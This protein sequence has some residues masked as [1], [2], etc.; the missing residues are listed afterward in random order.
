MTNTFRVIE[1]DD[2]NFPCLHTWG[3]G[4]PGGSVVKNLP[5]NA[6]DAGD[7]GLVLGLGRS[8][9]IGNGNPLQ[10]SYLGNSMET[11]AWLGYS[12]WGTKSQTQLK[13]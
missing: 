1:H 7:A 3:L 4:F 9:G 6:E 8:P 11:G 10:Y 12:P 13:G 2:G 5:A